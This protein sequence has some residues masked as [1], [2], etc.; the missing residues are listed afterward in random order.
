[1]N[2]NRGEALFVLAPEKPA[3]KRALFREAIM[4][5]LPRPA[6]G[7][8]PNSR[9]IPSTN[10]MTNGASAQPVFTGTFGLDPPEPPLRK[11]ATSIQ[12]IEE[13]FYRLPP[14]ALL[15]VWCRRTYNETI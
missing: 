9:F 2:P 15:L 3:E 11:V 1:M 7:P 12:A 4:R 14:T 5:R 6:L 8:E 10:E 13:Q